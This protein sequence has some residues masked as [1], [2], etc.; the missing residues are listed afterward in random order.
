MTR[1]FAAVG[2]ALMAVTLALPASVRAVTYNYQSKSLSESVYCYGYDSA[3]NT[4]YYL[5]AYA[6]DY[7]DHVP[8]GGANDY[9]YGYVY[10]ETY[11]YSTGEL[12][13]GYGQVTNQSIASQLTSASM[14]ATIT[15][16]CYDTN[17][18]DPVT[19]YYTLVSTTEDV[20]VDITLTGTGSTYKSTYHSTSKSP[21]YFN[22]VYSSSG[23]S[24]DA[25][26]TVLVG[27]QQLPATINCYGS[28]S[29]GKSSSHVN[30]TPHY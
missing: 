13:Y 14:S 6:S 20:P 28:I 9:T 21:P 18:I 12:C 5:S 23:T 8:G 22:S 1:R 25:T 10:Y 3:T 7:R 26:D 11:D 19:G 27:G 30:Y 24:R 16:N 2:L 29:S 15:L 4:N 17:T